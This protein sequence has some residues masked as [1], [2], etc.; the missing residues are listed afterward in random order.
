MRAVDS[1]KS[2]DCKQHQHRQQ[3]QPINDASIAQPVVIKLHGREHDD[4]TDRGPDALLDYIIKL[5]AVF[6][7]CHYCRG[8]VNHDHAKQRQA[9]GRREKPFVWIELLCHNYLGFEFR[10]SSFELLVCGSTFT[11]FWV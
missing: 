2:E 10:V 1:A 4:E 5:V 9:D 8:A 3:K 6:A 7:L 11:E